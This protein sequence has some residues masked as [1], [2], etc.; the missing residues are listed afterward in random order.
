MDHPDMTPES[1]RLL[2]LQTEARVLQS[3]EGQNIYKEQLAAVAK[4]VRQSMAEQTFNKMSI[5]DN[6]KTVDEEI[7]KFK[8][9]R[10]EW[11]VHK[12]D[13]QGIILEFLKEKVDV[14]LVEALKQLQEAEHEYAINVEKEFKKLSDLAKDKYNAEYGDHVDFEESREELTETILDCL[15]DVMDKEH[16]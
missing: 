9:E 11:A 12:S 15:R 3:E 10:F 16:V 4:A 14:H 13:R 1:F 2:M 7:E 5:H 8:A 6:K